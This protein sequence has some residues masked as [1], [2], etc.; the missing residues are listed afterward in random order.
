MHLKDHKISPSKVLCTLS[1]Y[2]LISCLTECIFLNFW[3]PS[4]KYT[5]FLLCNSKL[6]ISSNSLILNTQEFWQCFHLV[7]T[8]ILSAQM[9]LLRLAEL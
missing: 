3:F 1:L 5:I 8:I 2:E 4:P 6:L 7:S 9:W